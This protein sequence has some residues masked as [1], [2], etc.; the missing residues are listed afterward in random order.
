MNKDN[1]NIFI[2][3]HHNAP[4]KGETWHF[5]KGKKLTPKEYREIM[6]RRET[7]KENLKT[8]ALIILIVV[9]AWVFLKFGI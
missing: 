1:K 9:R 2:S 8:T 4:P 7:I 5:Y 6:K 3:I